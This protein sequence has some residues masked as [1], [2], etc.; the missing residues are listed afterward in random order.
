[1]RKIKAIFRALSSWVER[2]SAA[3]GN[4]SA[5]L[6]LV[7]VLLTVGQVIL[8]YFFG[9]SFVALQELSWHMFGLI[10]LLGAAEVLKRDQHVRVDTFYST[11]SQRVKALIDCAGI[12]IFLLPSCLVIV[13]F[14]W[15]YCLFS[16][17]FDNPHPLDRISSTIFSEDSALYSVSHRLEGFA[18]NTFL[19]GEVSSDPGG[20]EA[21]WMI[22]AAIPLGFLALLLQS[23]VLFHRKLKII[24]KDKS[25]S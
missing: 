24:F 7:L 12:L 2:F 3:L 8:R 22:K 20:L 25:L 6:C 17:G 4:I 9:Q 5:W 19:V 1:M 10:F 11:R 23:I 18:R 21:R 15:L 16:L 14:G 13:Y